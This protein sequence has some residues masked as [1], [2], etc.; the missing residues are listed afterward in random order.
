MRHILPFLPFS[1]ALALCLTSAPA[2]EDKRGAT[3]TAPKHN[4]Q[5]HAQWALGFLKDAA[6]HRQ[7]KTEHCPNVRFI[8]WLGIPDDKLDT[9]KRVMNVWLNQMSFE[10][11]PS[12]P[13]DVPGTDGRV[14]WFDLSWYRWNSDAW[15]AVAERDRTFREPWVDCRIG[16][17]LR[18]LIHVKPKDIKI[19]HGYHLVP[20]EAIVWAPQLFRDTIETDRQP[21]YYD[22]LFARQ[23]FGE[24]TT[25]T[26]IERSIV[27]LQQ[28]TAPASGLGRRARMTFDVP[29][30]AIVTIDGDRTKTHTV[31]TP[32]L[33]KEGAYPV[34]V[35]SGT[36]EATG[37]INVA[38]GHVTTVT[39]KTG[40]KTTYQRNRKGF[41]A[42]DF[43]RTDKEWDAAFGIDV[44]QL[45]E[46]EQDLTLEYGAII[47]GGRDNPKGGSIVTLNNRLIV[48]EPGALHAMRTFDVFKTQG[49]KDYLENAPKLPA[50]FR[51]RKVAFDASELLSYLPNGGQAGF[52][53]DG[54]GKR[55][56]IAANKAADGRGASPQR[57][58]AGVRTPGDCVV[59]HGPTGGYIL[60][61]NL[62]QKVL[63]GGID[64][65]FK[66]SADETR[67][68]GFYLGW[69]KR[70]KAFQDPYH[71]LVA[72]C[73]KERPPVVADWLNLRDDP[74]M[75]AEF[76]N[77]AQAAKQS[78]G[79]TSTEYVKHFVEFREHFD[80]PQ[81]TKTL[82]AELGMP[83]EMMKRLAAR[84]I[85]KEADGKLPVQ[86]TVRLS[87]LVQDMPTPRAVFDDDL[88]P[89][90]GLLLYERREKTNTR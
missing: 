27:N 14:Q 41:V 11:A 20:L 81:S 23:R 88:F 51:K 67:F 66:D 25:A 10:K 16:Q 1:L 26:A 58:S 15:Q 62:I 61:V 56:E 54:A 4:P 12:I 63:E 77:R 87:A 64:F 45:Y 34:V 6:N 70:I 3:S 71:D 39:W 72:E 82:A 85:F 79:W 7:F 43:P 78:K 46:T 2:Q 80:G 22:L 40:T 59:C 83:V 21:S 50:L 8:S 35:R 44:S 49:D 17:E 30:D 36:K 74:A 24:Y 33:D 18:D 32:E 69:E 29:D 90:L 55:A 68:R 42:A 31:E 75:L 38:P 28:A 86:N 19:V 60:P 65:H 73:T 84:P 13:R 47:E 52:L 76:A 57:L 89:V 48:D 53:T 9:F 37:S 5:S